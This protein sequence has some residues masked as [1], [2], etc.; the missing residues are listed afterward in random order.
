[1]SGTIK[2]TL[3]NQSSGTNNSQVV[4]FQKNEADAPEE[5][6]VAWKVIDRCSPGKSYPFTFGADLAIAASDSYGNYTPQLP[7]TTGQQYTLQPSAGGDRL[8]ATGAAVAAENI[9]LLNG[10]TQGAINASIYRDGKLLATKT[11]ITPLQKAT[12]LFTP[13]IWVGIVSEV[14]AGQVLNSAII[15]NVNAQIGLVGITEANIIMSGGGPDHPYTF[16]LE[17]VVYE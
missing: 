14:L 17:N 6:A 9:E 11:G 13:T 3:V 5:S 15:S 8:A 4:I 7:A 12:F 1:M 2:L 16:T 10:L